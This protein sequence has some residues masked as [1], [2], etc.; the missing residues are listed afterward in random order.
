MVR[1]LLS[2]GAGGTILFTIPGQITQ[3]RTLTIDLRTVQWVTPYSVNTGP[4]SYP[5]SGSVPNAPNSPG[6]ASKTGN[7]TT[8]V[9]N[10]A[11]E[12]VPK[13]EVLTTIEFHIPTSE[14]RTRLSVQIPQGYPGAGQTIWINVPPPEPQPPGGWFHR[15]F[16]PKIHYRKVKVEVD[17]TQFLYKNEKMGMKDYAWSLFLILLWVYPK[18]YLVFVLLSGDSLNNY[19]P[20]P[21]PSCPPPAT[22][23][24]PLPPPI[25][26][27]PPPP[28]PLFTSPPPPTLPP[29]YE[30]AGDNG[31]TDNTGGLPAANALALWTL[32][33]DVLLMLVCV[34]Q[35]F[36]GDP[37]YFPGAGLTNNLFTIIFGKK[38]S[39]K[40]IEDAFP[41][42]K[43]MIMGCAGYFPL[44]GV[45]VAESHQQ[46]I[47]GHGIVK[48]SESILLYVVHIGTIIW[49]SIEAMKYFFLYMFFY[50]DVI[51]TY[52]KFLGLGAFFCVSKEEQDK[53][54]PSLSSKRGQATYPIYV[55]FWELLGS[56]TV[57][58]E[59]DNKLLR[60]ASNAFSVVTSC[61]PFTK[62]KKTPE[63][64]ES[65]TNPP[66]EM[67]QKL[68]TNHMNPHFGASQ[69]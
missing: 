54:K 38:L 30:P 3:S 64:L 27:S 15:M 52:L 62:N 12:A 59:M 58:E 53:M 47:T 22:L 61:L 32:L 39:V 20:P 63:D 8:P 36:K 4:G 24:P 41:W 33:F 69:S 46:A 49:L 43:K 57:T 28:Y 37:V 56:A 19:P 34:Y 40:Y 48:E 13:Q 55:F 44:V 35:F 66:L 11:Q 29:G 42:W 18:I 23:P 26:L 6:N 68:Y 21:S 9:L 31:N 25:P 50:V 5:S 1:F 10:V 67:P 60:T 14:T 16:T 45:M 17:V 2:Q 7:F 65:S 51:G